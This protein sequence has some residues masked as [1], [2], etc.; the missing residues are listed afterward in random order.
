ME[1]TNKGGRP[2]GRTYARKLF[3]YTN[4]AGVRRV[5][6]IA[7]RRQSSVAAVIRS[8]IEEEAARLGLSA[9]TSTPSPADAT[10]A[11]E[12]FVALLEKAQGSATG[13]LTPEE[14][15]REITLAREEVRAE[16]REAARARRL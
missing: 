3:A 1:R 8:L 9:D 7:R 15:E 6:E 2:R 10:A 5:Q 11:R 4:E 14:I 13:D 16:S 12:R